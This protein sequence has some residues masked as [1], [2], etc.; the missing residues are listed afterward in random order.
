MLEYRLYIDESGTH[1][2][3]HVKDIR[4][5]YLGLTG[6]L[7]DKRVNDVMVQPQMEALKRAYFSYDIDMPPILVRQKIRK[8]EGVFKVLQDDAVNE[9][10][11]HSILNYLTGL[12]PFVRI[13]TVAIDKEQHIKKYPTETY[14]SYEYSLEVLLW[15]V[16]GYLHKY[17]AQADV[18][19]ESRGGKEDKPLKEAYNKC[20][21][22]GAK[23][24]RY[25]TAEGYQE[26]FPA[27]S[28]MVRKKGENVAGLQIADLVAAGQKLKT[29]EEKGKPLPKPMTKFMKQVNSAIE[30]MVILRIGRYLLP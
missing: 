11:E 30:P 8:K 27:K 17:G 22:V 28:L 1:D 23:N 10:W 4:N 2:Y 26:A 6:V 9:K 24:R 7:I 13:Y 20:L 14:N 12:I 16:R 18:M 15:R 19:S 25:G 5:R 3:T 21:T 29:L